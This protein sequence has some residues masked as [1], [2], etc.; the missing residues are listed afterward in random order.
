MLQIFLFSSSYVCVFYVYLQ[1]HKNIIGKSGFFCLCSDGVIASCTRFSKNW[2]WQIISHFWEA[3]PDKALQKSSRA[4]TMNYW[5]RNCLKIRVNCHLCKLFIWP[6]AFLPSVSLLCGHRN[7]QN[8]GM[9]G[10][11]RDLCGSSSPPP[12]PKQGHLQQAAQDRV[13]AG[14]EYLQ[15]RRLH[16]LPGQPVPVLHHPQSELPG[17]RAA[18]AS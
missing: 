17:S 4:K 1:V 2:H 7:S 9:F 16:N 6:G 10:V 5:L 8:H 13:Q 14:F 3:C 12:L 18:A 11:G 15:R